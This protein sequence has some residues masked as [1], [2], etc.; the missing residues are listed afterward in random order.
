MYPA[1]LKLQTSFG[2][3]NRMHNFKHSLTV[4]VNGQ[5]HLHADL[6]TENGQKHLHTH[7]LLRSIHMFSYLF[8]ITMKCFQV[9][10]SLQH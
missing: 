4:T 8:T 1:N 5:N 10:I 3:D 2:N 7:S 6:V 9:V